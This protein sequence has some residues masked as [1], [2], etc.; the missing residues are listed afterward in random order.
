MT[1]PPALTSA[2]T[3]ATTAGT[4]SPRSLKR[5][6]SA[7]S[8]DIKDDNNIK[9]AVQSKRVPGSNAPDTD[10][11]GPARA[12]GAAATT[13]G[14]GGSG[15]G[16]G[17]VALPTFLAARA[18]CGQRHTV[19]VSTRG[20][21]WACGR[22]RSG[23]LGLDPEKVAETASPLRVP[24]LLEGGGGGG[25]AAAQEGGGGEGSVGA[26]QAAAGRAHTL[27]LLSDGRVVGFGSDECG[28]LGR[29]AATTRSSSSSGSFPPDPS[30]SG[31]SAATT[32]T[33]G[34][35]DNKS[36][37]DL[38]VDG[39]SVSAAAPP[40]YHWKPAVIE[41][42]RG[43]WIASVSAGGEQTFAM[44]LGDEQCTG[45]VVV[46]PP[47]PP[48]T[49]AEAAAGVESPI[50]ETLKTVMTGEE[51]ALPMEKG[52]AGSAPASLAGGPPPGDGGEKGEGGGGGRLVRQGSEAM[53]MR[54]SFSL[55]VGLRMRTVGELM[56]LIRRAE[57]AAAGSGD[58]AEGQG[59]QAGEEEA[60][61]VEV[62]ARFSTRICWRFFLCG[63]VSGAPSGCRLSS[64]C[65]ERVPSFVRGSVQV[66]MQVTKVV[67][68]V[69][70]WSIS[71]PHNGTPPP[72]PPPK[73]QITDN[74]LFCFHMTCLCCV[75]LSSPVANLPPR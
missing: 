15:G 6:P 11:V 10:G 4:S 54:R 39:G 50:A 56:R 60:A 73:V 66:G 69:C 64:F 75:Q 31:S 44:A 14:G 52:A 21:A 25:G 1:A 37:N 53:F 59:Q 55:P 23:Q 65:L 57:D 61:V 45:A 36:G 12:S 29:S 26:I 70:S 19:L 48:A 8:G 49:S 33:G 38:E 40:S 51:E 67:C 27:L 16:G 72:P 41:A 42:L 28:T 58:Q 32:A 18:A 22:N 2:S 35:G 47:L 43:Q 20:E 63:S 34:D 74:Q 13:G 9:S 30:G 3:P 17:G 5:P 24:L 68:R 46:S 62:R 71:P 7:P